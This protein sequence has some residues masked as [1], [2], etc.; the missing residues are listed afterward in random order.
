MQCKAGG[1]AAFDVD[2]DQGWLNEVPYG[3]LKAM[4]DPNTADVTARVIE[5]LGSCQLEMPEERI[6]KALTFLYQEQE[7]DGS[8]FGRWG[9]NYIYGTSGVLSA[10][11][12]LNPEQ[13]RPQMEQGINWLISCQNSDGGWGE[14]CWS[15]NDPSF[16]GQGVSTAS[17]TAWAIIGLLD[18]GEGLGTLAKDPIEKG[19]NYLLTHQTAEGT[20]EEAEFTGT[21]FP[22]HFY[23]RYHLY[24]HYFPL[25][26]LGRYQKLSDRC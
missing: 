15:Y 19:I 7:N 14:T 17:Q 16:K 4:I 1:W 18:G 23:I 21:G 6:Q 3:D 11:A 24:R 5:M 2:N 25:I 12:V 26:A 20:W 10:L 13:H 22:C 8:W 9:V